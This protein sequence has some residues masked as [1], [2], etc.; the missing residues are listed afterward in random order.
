MNTRYFFLS[1]FLLFSA[2]NGIAQ[3]NKEQI[4][5]VIQ[6]MFDGMR[7]NDSMMIK[8]LFTPETNLSSIFTNS[9]GQVIKRSGSIANFITAVG[10]P[11]E[12]TW[13]EQIWSYE[14]KIDDPMGQAWTEYTFYLDDDMS[15]CGVNVFEMI[16]LQEGWK[17]SGITD[18]RR[19][20]NCKTKAQAEINKL[21]DNWHHAA[22]IA[23]EETFFGSMTADGVY[24]GTDAGERWLRDE[25]KIWSKKFF[26]GESAWSFK[27]HSRIVNFSEDEQMGW[28]DELLDTWMGPCRGSGV[29]VKTDD[30]WKIKHYHLAIAV[31]NE[32]VDGYLKL[33][34]KPRKK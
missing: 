9:E 26:E 17:I 10:R 27:A 28:F 7:A 1:L 33:I 11:H 21:M 13:D 5:A 30:G 24:I 20:V 8:D 6:Q 18:T 12:K 4:K 32:Q 14:I 25:M 23:D 19:N 3:D 15:H 22:S 31:P 2:G 16:H 29:V 34:G